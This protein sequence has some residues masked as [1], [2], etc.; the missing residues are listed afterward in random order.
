MTLASMVKNTF[1]YTPLGWENLTLKYMILIVGE[2][3]FIPRK[4]LE[5][6]LE[7]RGLET[8]YIQHEVLNSVSSE[9][10]F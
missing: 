3:F 1:E 7:G 6:G 5:E 2:L 10:K 4:S 9:P 8:T